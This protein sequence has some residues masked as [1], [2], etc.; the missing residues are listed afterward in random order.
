MGHHLTKISGYNKTLASLHIFSVGSQFPPASA[1]RPLSHP[2]GCKQPPPQ[3]CPHPHTAHLYSLPKATYLGASLG[4][5]A[6]AAIDWI[7]TG[8]ISHSHRCSPYKFGAQWGHRPGG[9]LQVGNAIHASCPFT[10]APPTSTDQS[11]SSHGPLTS[12]LRTLP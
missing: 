11:R 2:P 8:S 7:Q 5:S 4:N 3:S 6:A 12:S 1:F 10:R 9:R